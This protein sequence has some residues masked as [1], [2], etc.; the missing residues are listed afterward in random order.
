M[1]ERMSECVM[2]VQKCTHLRLGEETG[3][4]QKEMRTQGRDVGHQSNVSLVDFCIDW[5]I[6]NASS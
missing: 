2:L 3:P 1:N 5:P 4:E 6:A